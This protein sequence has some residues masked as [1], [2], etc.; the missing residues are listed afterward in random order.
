[1]AREQY[2]I[3][4]CIHRATSETDDSR[5]IIKDGQFCDEIVYIPLIKKTTN[6]S[7]RWCHWINV[8][9][10]WTWQIRIIIFNKYKNGSVM[11]GLIVTDGCFTCSTYHFVLWS[12]FQSVTK[13]LAVP[14]EEL[15]QV[16]FFPWVV[17]NKSKQNQFNFSRDC[18]N[19]PK[20]N[21]SVIIRTW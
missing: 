1:M 10:L 4:T 17:K 9:V 2:C 20:I 16:S 18:F 15:A 12:V 8:E 19:Q 21:S 6:I 7:K 3:C 5:W 14:A 13:Y 11:S